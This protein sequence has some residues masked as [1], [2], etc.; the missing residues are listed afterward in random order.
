MARKCDN[1]L[2]AE[3]S[4]PR[5]QRRIRESILGGLRGRLGAKYLDTQEY[6]QHLQA[7]TESKREEVEKPLEEKASPIFSLSSQWLPA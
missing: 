7:I 1:G 6:R 5:C 4:H 3:R 2:A